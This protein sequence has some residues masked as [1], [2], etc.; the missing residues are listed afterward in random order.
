MMVIDSIFLA[1]EDRAIH[2]LVPLFS[3]FPS[4]ILIKSILLFLIIIMII[5]V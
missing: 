1:L 2:F 5:V 3:S 4:S